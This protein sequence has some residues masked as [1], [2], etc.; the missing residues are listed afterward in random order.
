MFLNTT[1]YHIL[2]S[3]NGKNPFFAVTT[4]D[5]YYMS[6]GHTCQHSLSQQTML[7]FSYHKFPKLA[8][9]NST[10]QLDLRNVSQTFPLDTSLFHTYHILKFNLMCNTILMMQ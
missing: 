2:I 4:H 3:I 1:F 8:S 10:Q 6:H 7:W 9:I 5:T